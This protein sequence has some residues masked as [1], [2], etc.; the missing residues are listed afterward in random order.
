MHRHFFTLIVISGWFLTNVVAAAEPPDSRPRAD[1]QAHVQVTFSVMG[2]VPYFVG[3]DEVLPLEIAHLPSVSEFVVHVG[4]I[5][6]GRTPCDEAVYRKVAGMLAKSAPRLF[7]IPGDNEWNDCQDPEA[8]WELWTRY[9]MRFHDR[10]RDS[11]PVAHQ[12]DREENFAFLRGGVLF[13]GINLVGGRVHDAE[14]WQRRHAMNVT[15]VEE[16]IRQHGHEASSMVV[17]AHA[18]PGKNHADFVDGFTAAAERFGKPVLFLHGDGHRWI[19]DRPFVAQN[20]LRVQVDQ[21]SL[22]PPILVTVTDD[23][24]D[25]FRFDRRRSLGQEGGVSLKDFQDP[26]GWMLA[27]RVEAGDVPRSWKMVQPG[28]SLLI[29][30]AEGK[31]GNVQ[32]IFAHGDAVVEVEFMIPKGSNSGIYLQ[33]RYEVQILDSYGKPADKLTVHDCGAIYERWD[34]NREPK[35]YEGRA[36]AVNACQR[37][38]E[39]QRFEIHFRAPRFDAFGNKTANAR[40]EKVIHNGTLLHEDVEVTG[41]TRGGLD[42][43]AVRAPLMIQGDHGP[44]AIR[45]LVIRPLE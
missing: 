5:K 36:P 4:D 45:R 15:W 22:A 42:G 10:W 31:A 13:L 39:W 34:E 6:T 14:E 26:Q 38:G 24:V 19:H 44:V 37:P 27:G 41:P 18:K 35:G 20:I 17:F 32:T 23:P 28:T 1:R 40:F 25:P 43:E 3:E 21:G 7:I 8:A 12:P 2:D 33:S 9:F 11:F 30:G 29:N 16:N